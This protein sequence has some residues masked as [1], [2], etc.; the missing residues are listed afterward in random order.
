MDAGTL[1]S[2]MF[3]AALPILEKDAADAK[4]FAKV[5]FAKIAQTIVSIG[6]QLASG[7]I[8]EGQA[9][10]LLEMQ[11]SASRNVLLTLKGLALLAVEEAINAALEVVKATVNTAIG[12]SLIA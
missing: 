12:F 10:L 5:E 9:G 2:Q 4:S 7:Q 8:T 1:A 6:E 3:G 11:T